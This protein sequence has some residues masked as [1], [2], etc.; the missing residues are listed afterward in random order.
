[1]F[2]TIRI[3]VHVSDVTLKLKKTH[4]KKNSPLFYKKTFEACEGV[5]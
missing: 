1:M 4:K 5:D 2:G 3:V